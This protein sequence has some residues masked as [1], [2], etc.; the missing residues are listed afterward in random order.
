MSTNS[1]ASSY[2]APAPLLP[3]THLP[4]SPPTPSRTCVQ[5]SL[6]K[7]CL[8][9]HS[10]RQAILRHAS[11]PVASAT[12][13]PTL[14]DP[15]AAPMPL[16]RDATPDASAS[17]AY[18]TAHAAYTAHAHAHAATA[19]HAHANATPAPALPDWAGALDAPAATAAPASALP[20]CRDLSAV[21]PL[22]VVN[23]GVVGP[24]TTA[25]SAPPR[26]SR[27]GNGGL[28][29]AVRLSD[30]LARMVAPETIGVSEPW[31]CGGC[32]RAQR[33]TRQARGRWEMDRVPMH[34]CV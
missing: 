11:S 29:T 2:D 22:S 33:A 5:P 10:Q 19:A 23:G 6:K 24:N 31:T 34:A 26:A 13:T 17:T 30:C 12:A 28:G 16:P 14:T 18:H 8:R 20:R 9:N 1:F 7:G 32:G 21:Q 3:P 27:T 15:D 4:P 25:R